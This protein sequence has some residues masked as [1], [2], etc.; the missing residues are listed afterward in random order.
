MLFQSCHC[1]QLPPPEVITN[2]QTQENYGERRQF[3]RWILNATI[4]PWRREQTR[5]KVF[6][7][8]LQVHEWKH[9]IFHDQLIHKRNVKI[10]LLTSQIG[11]PHP[12]NPSGDRLLEESPGS[13]SSRWEAKRSFLWARRPNEHA[14][15]HNVQNKKWL[16]PASSSVTFDQTRHVRQGK[17]GAAAAPRPPAPSGWARM[18][19]A[20]EKKM[21]KFMQNIP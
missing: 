2:P 1:R 4:F 14:R 18:M 9:L 10:R 17:I 6:T 19:W 15:I 5:N 8:R 7:R 12:A 13:T 21:I 3:A 20:A 11:N 16:T